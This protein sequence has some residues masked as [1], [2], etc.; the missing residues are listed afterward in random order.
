MNSDL[1][2]FTRLQTH[3]IC[4]KIQISAICKREPEFHI[5]I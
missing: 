2:T 1:N 5:T 3:A 4:Q